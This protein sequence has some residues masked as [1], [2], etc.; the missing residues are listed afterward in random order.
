MN[1]TIKPRF[2]KVSSLRTIANIYNNETGIYVDNFEII[3]DI[4]SIKINIEIIN[5]NKPK[6]M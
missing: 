1:D 6:D 5:N 4:N 2:N 3:A